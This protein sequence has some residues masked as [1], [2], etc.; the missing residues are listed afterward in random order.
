[1]IQQFHDS[2]TLTRLRDVVTIPKE[3]LDQFMNMM[4]SIFHDLKS[5]P[6]PAGQ[7]TAPAATQVPQPSPLTP[8]NLEKQTQALKQAQNRAATKPA[9]PPAAPTTTQ[10]PFQFGVGKS[11]AGNPEYFGEQRI[12]QLNLPPPRKK[13]KTGTGQASPPAPQPQA[14]NSSSPQVNAPSP[15]AARKPAPPKLTCP[16]PGCEMSSIGFLSEEALN[17]HRQEEH[18]KP[19]ENPM[20]FLQEQM[21]AAL[22]LDAQGKP[23]APPKPSNQAV[24]TPAAPPMT[25]SL[26]KQ[27]QKPGPQPMSRGASMQRNGSAAGTNPKAGDAG[28]PGRTTVPGKPTAGTPQQI[29]T[30]DDPWAASTIDPQDLFSSALDQSLDPFGAVPDFGPYR[31]VTPRNDD[32]YTP[33]SSASKESGAS[34]MT[35]SDITE[36]AALD[37][38]ISGWQQMMEGDLLWDMERIGVENFEEMGEGD[39]E[40]FGMGNGGDDGVN[41]G[42]GLGL[43]MGEM[44]MEGMGNDFSKPFRVDQ[45]L[46][47]GL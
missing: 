22:G 17:N 12:T 42:F 5:M 15:V 27:G 1:V 33:E 24:S 3:E 7:E 34:S 4:E 36:G 18:I 37:I 23:K 16:E 26:S 41:G 20:G 31:S 14:A 10:P 28:T 19:F 25:A 13:A 32:D 30:A 44:G 47:S 11:P 21:T 2:E 45:E 38:E 35:N 39:V 29:P 6:R 9:Q 43:G 8:A 46:Y 40:M